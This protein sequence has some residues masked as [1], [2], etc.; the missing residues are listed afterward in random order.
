VRVVTFVG[1]RV[2]TAGDDRQLTVRNLGGEII[3][4]RRLPHRVNGLAPSADGKHLAT[5][6]SNG[7]VYILR[8]PLREPR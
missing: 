7:T 1:E 6:N 3:S 4:E 2:V 8:L 5:A